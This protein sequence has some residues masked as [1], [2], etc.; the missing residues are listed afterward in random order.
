MARKNSSDLVHDLLW[1]V[2]DELHQNPTAEDMQLDLDEEIDLPWEDNSFATGEEDPAWSYEDNGFN[3]FQTVQEY[4]IHC[5]YRTMSFRNILRAGKEI[6]R[7]MKPDSHYYMWTTKDFLLE[8]LVALRMR[9]YTFKNMIVWLKTSK[10]GRLTYGMGHWFRNGWEAMNFGTRGNPGRPAEATTQPNWF[11]APKPDK[12]LLPNGKG[13]YTKHSRKPQEAYDL[14]C[15]NSPG[16]RL[17]MFQ[18]GT[19]PGFYCWGDEAIEGLTE[20]HEVDLPGELIRFDDKL[21]FGVDW[22]AGDVSVLLNSEEVEEIRIM[23]DLAEQFCGELP[24]PAM[25]IKDRFEQASIVLNGIAEQQMEEELLGELDPVEEAEEEIEAEAETEAEAEPEYEAEAEPELLPEGDFSNE[26]SNEEAAMDELA[27]LET[28]SDSEASPPENTQPDQPIQ[29][30]QPIQSKP[31]EYAQI[32]KAYKEN[33]KWWFDYGGTTFGPYN[34]MRA[35]EDQLNKEK[36]RSLG[37][38]TDE[39]MDA[40]L[41]AMKAKWPTLSGHQLLKMM[42][43][44]TIDREKLF[45]EMNQNAGG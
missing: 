38:E 43:G 33:D 26:D 10:A 24:L 29:P 21:S 25:K 27:K 35:A 40:W 18:R 15:R 5:P 23:I 32:E 12:L 13:G 17:S 20:P 9:G 37:C 36:C 4:R 6:S 30:A 11:C 39:E 1:R 7:V 41:A 31:I 2:L 45:E 44:G 3:G 34:T 16:P 42:A 22:D 19:R 14:I 28:T 8:S